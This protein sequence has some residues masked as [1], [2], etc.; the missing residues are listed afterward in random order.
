MSTLAVIKSELQL[1]KNQEKNREIGGV[2]LAHHLVSNI[3]LLLSLFGGFNFPS[4]HLSL[5]FL[6]LV[7]L[8]ALLFF[9]FLPL[10]RELGFVLALLQNEAVQLG[11]ALPHTQRPVLAHCVQLSKHAHEG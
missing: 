5:L 11:V 8:L 7:P 2:L 10:S 6:H 1:E 9:L 3:L 4:D